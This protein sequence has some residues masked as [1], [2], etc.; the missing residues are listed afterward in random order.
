MQFSYDFSSPTY[1]NSMYE[2]YPPGIPAVHWP[3]YFNVSNGTLVTT[4]SA[5]CYP[6][7][8]SP[9]LAFQSKPM[10]LDIAAKGQWYQYNFTVN[11]TSGTRSLFPT[12]RFCSVARMCLCQCVL[13]CL[14]QATLAACS[15]CKTA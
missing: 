9:V 7:A 14:R 8:T 3:L 1:F 11:V 6:T 2:Y 10:Y 5:Q 13:C 15:G 4:A 12:I